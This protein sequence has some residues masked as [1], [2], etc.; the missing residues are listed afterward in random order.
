[1]EERIVDYLASV[2]EVGLVKD[3]GWMDNERNDHARK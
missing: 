3:S 2:F 1:V